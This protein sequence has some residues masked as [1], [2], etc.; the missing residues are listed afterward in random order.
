MTGPPAPAQRGAIAGACCERA[1]GPLRLREQCRPGRDVVVPFDQG[2]HGPSA[3]KRP[4][5]ERPNGGGDF[6]SMIVDEQE[7]A[8]FVRVLRMAA[9]VNLADMLHGERFEIGIRTEA[10]IDGLNEHV[11]HVEQ[12]AA[13]RPPH[14]LAQELDLAH[15]RF[16]IGHIGRRVFEKHLPAHRILH[17]TD[18]FADAGQCL[19]GIGERQEVVEIDGIVARPGQVLGEQGRFVAVGE[20][21][22]T[23]KMAGI[24]R[25]GAADGQPDAMQRERIPLADGRQIGMGRPAGPHIVLGV[26]LEPAD[27]RR[28][29]ENVAIMLRLKPD[30]APRRNRARP[31]CWG[32]GH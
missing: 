20:R 14:G 17:F 25:P 4:F 23:G 12:Q 28:A 8:I 18:V 5:I 9:Q 16:G 21:A 7:R 27:I 22:Q 29:I 13:A 15:R 32:V 1:I 24:E 19:L 31:E 26:D 10:V 3:R 6:A 2:R 30:S 11:V